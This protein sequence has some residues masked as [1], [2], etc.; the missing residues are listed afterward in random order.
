MSYDYQSI[1]NL[2]KLEIQ[3][4]V[5]VGLVKS[6]YKAIKGKER[7]HQLG[8]YIPIFTRLEKLELNLGNSKKL[9]W[10]KKKNVKYL[11]VVLDSNLTLI[12]HVKR[13][14]RMYARFSKLRKIF[15]KRFSKSNNRHRQVSFVQRLGRASN[16]V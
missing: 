15:H 6:T 12:S 10:E 4:Y 16:N 1:V 5:S 2:D 11:G 14:L 13:R 8:D 3:G 7:L 9:K